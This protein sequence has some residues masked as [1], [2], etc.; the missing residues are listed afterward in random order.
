MLKN[1]GTDALT[2]LTD[3]LPLVLK[4]FQSVELNNPVV[5]IL[6]IGI[7]VV[8]A[9]VI[10]PFAFTVKLGIDVAVPNEPTFELT[11]FKINGMEGAVPLEV[12][13]PLASPVAVIVID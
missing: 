1:D 4:A 12:E 6:A 5:V 10:N 13:I 11:V 7:A 9:A 8:P 3:P 2:L